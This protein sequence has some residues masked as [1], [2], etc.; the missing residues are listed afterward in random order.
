MIE[1]LTNY[2]PA[3]TQSR[4]VG[5]LS[6]A[7]TLLLAGDIV[8]RDRHHALFLAQLDLKYHVVLLAECHFGC[9]EIKLPHPHKTLIIKPCSL[10]A[11]RQKAFAPCLQ[12]LRVMQAQDL[13]VVDQQS[14][15]LDGRQHF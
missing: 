2:S 15:S 10:F 7:Q 5:L 9:S 4:F 1:C 13:D 12:C 11:A 14:R 8:S 3:E 6:A